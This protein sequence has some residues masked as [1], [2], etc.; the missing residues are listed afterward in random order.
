M[1]RAD[2]SY[3]VTDFNGIDLSF[4]PFMLMLAMGLL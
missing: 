2:K 3:L 4:S 1:E